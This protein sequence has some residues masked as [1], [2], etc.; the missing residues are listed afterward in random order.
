MSGLPKVNFLALVLKAGT[1]EGARPLFQALIAQLVNVK[2]GT[3]RQVT[4]NPGDWGLDCIVGALND[5][6]FNWQAKF[7]IDGVGGVQQQEIR[8]SFNQFLSKAK[9]EGYTPGGWTLCVPVDMDAA[10]TKWWDTWKKKMEKEHEIPMFLWDATQLESLL[11]APDA[12]HVYQAYFGDATPAA[13]KPELKT[14]PVP[15]DIPFEEMLFIKQLRRANVAEV[16][17]AKRQFFN[18]DVMRREVAD[19][20]VD[21]ELQELESCLAEVHSLWEIGF[22]QKCEENPSGNLLPGLYPSVMRDIHGIHLSKPQGKIPMGLVHRLG[23]MH[24]VVDKGDAGWVRDFRALAAL[25]TPVSEEIG[26]GGQ[27]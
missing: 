7:F 20:A 23:T 1:K 27:T 5:L 18:A 8:E 26:D 24:H 13:A 25:H 16:E 21:A 22:N 11:I 15:T 19:K 17:Q 14:L 3:V 10:A 12:S 4:P 2:H 9:Q 6:L